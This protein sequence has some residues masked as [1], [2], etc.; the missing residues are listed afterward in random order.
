MILGIGCDIVKIARVTF[1]EERLAY[2][3]L[4][5]KELE[6]YETFHGKRAQEFLAGRFAAKEAI[7]KALSV[8]D[9][10]ISQIEILN[11]EKGKPFCTFKE[12]QIHISISHED[13]YALAYAIVER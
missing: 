8:E 3:I 7:F 9:L 1:N 2:R 10:V 12:Y 6:M 13:E 4:T 11:D 5:K